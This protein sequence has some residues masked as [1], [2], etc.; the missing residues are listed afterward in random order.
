[1]SQAET[2]NASDEL[3]A[4]QRSERVKMIGGSDAITI[5]WVAGEDL[6][7]V[8]LGEF[9]D[10]AIEFVRSRESSVEIEAWKNR[11]KHGLQMFW[12]K[13]KGDALALK[14]VIEDKISELDR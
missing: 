8:P 2:Q 9:A 11:N 4:F 13:H 7:P 14:K 3:E 6:I 10:K 1:M 5:Q 12:A